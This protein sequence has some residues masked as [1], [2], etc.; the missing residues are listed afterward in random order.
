MENQPDA[1]AEVFKVLSFLGALLLWIGFFLLGIIA[2]RYEVV[3]KQWTG[4]KSLMFA[5]SGILIYVIVISAQYLALSS[6]PD[7]QKVLDAVAY[8]SL[9]LSSGACLWV[10]HRFHSVLIRIL[11]PRKKA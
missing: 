7:L 1:L 4:W 6:S 8:G 10:V 3:F 9:L 2:R 5:P 11:E